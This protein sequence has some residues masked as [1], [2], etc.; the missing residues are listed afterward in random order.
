[1]WP[2]G[3][4]SPIDGLLVPSRRMETDN[5]GVSEALGPTSKAD[6]FH[7]LTGEADELLDN[8]TSPTAGEG[9]EGTHKGDSWSGPGAQWGERPSRQV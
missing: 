6:G 8:M 9:A 2:C 5:W 1:M 4:F 7:H 3:D